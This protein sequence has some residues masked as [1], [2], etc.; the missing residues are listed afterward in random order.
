MTQKISTGLANHLLRGGSIE[1]AFPN[2]FEIR[3]FSSFPLHA[4]DAEMANRI[5]TIMT[6]GIDIPTGGPLL[7][8]TFDPAAIVNGIMQKNPA[9]TWNAM[10]QLNGTTATYRI[11]LFNGGAAP[12]D[13]GSFSTTIPRI[14][15]TIG[16]V[17]KDIVLAD[18]IF[19]S[20]AEPVTLANF[21]QAF[22]I[23]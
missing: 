12:Y 3:I 5:A 8:L 2:G 18:P 22:K 14:Q 10:S 16:T 9:E 17:G 7:P 15:G 21:Y 23:A 13:D 19:N 20:G 4:D 11:A 6:N 1:S